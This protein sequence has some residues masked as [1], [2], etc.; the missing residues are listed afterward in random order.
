MF[1]ICVLPVSKIQKV[2]LTR[3]QEGQG[4]VQRSVSSVRSQV[5]FALRR[6]AGRFEHA[7]CD[8]HFY[9]YCERVCTALVGSAGS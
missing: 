8:M 5:S 4:A 7:V 3:A 9:V 2:L 6:V 1:C